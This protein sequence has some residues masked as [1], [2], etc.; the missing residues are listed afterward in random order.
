MKINGSLALEHLSTL[1][2]IKTLSAKELKDM[3]FLPFQELFQ[4]LQEFYPLIHKQADIEVIHEG[5]YVYRIPSE[6]PTKEPILFMSHMDV[7]PVG[8]NTKSEWKYDGFSGKIV[9]DVVWGRGA[10]DMKNH[11]VAYFE[12]IEYALSQEETF[13]QDI[14]FCLG[15]DEEQGGNNGTKYVA[16]YFKDKGIHFGL[17]LDEGGTITDGILGLKEEIALIGTCEKG[18]AEV[19]ITYRGEGGHGSMPPKHTALGKVCEA[20]CKLENHQM[21]MKITEPL[22][23]MLEKLC[24]FLHGVTKL[25]LQ[26]NELFSPVVKKALEAS[27]DSNA[28]ARTTTAITMAKGADAPNIL[29]NQASIT[30]NF[31]L[32]PGDTLE[33]VKQHIRQVIGKEYDINIVIGR[34]ASKL[35]NIDA[36]FDIVANSI[37]EA[38]PPLAQ[39]VPFIMV[40]GTDSI[41]FDDLCDHIYKFGPFRCNKKERA[42]IH[43]I[44]ESLSK[45]NMEIGIRYFYR[46]L[47]N[48]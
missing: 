29:P 11:M 7:V 39:A 37:K 12:A 32:L 27:P 36:T 47:Q 10:K 24:P 6:K 48:Y 45:D 3:D 1:I 19:E 5:A 21:P 34:H 35:S 44:N 22:K 2:Q 18:Y 4:R 23:V 33:D 42:T 20:A 26:H 41:Y 13:D 46:I 17:V 16:Q 28:L 30:V 31:R 15:Y 8:E 25:A 40:G 38:Y 14:Y 43:G 9:D